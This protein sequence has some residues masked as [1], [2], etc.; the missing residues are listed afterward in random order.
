MVITDIRDLKPA[1]EIA[2][3]INVNTKLLATLALLSALQHS[4][5]PVLMI[6]CESK[7]GSFDHFSRMM[8]RYPFDLISAKLKPH[9]QTLDWLFANI[10][11]A[12]VLLVDS[13]LEIL[14]PE[15]IKFC[16]EF[17]DEEQTFGCGF[18]NGPQWLTDHAG[19][20][21]EKAYY[22]ERMWMPVTLLKTALVK[23]ALKAG[24]TFDAFILYNDFMPSRR[25]SSA[26]ARLRHR[27]P[28]LRKMDIKFP[29]LF[30]KTFYGHNPALVYYDTGADI[31][32]Y[33][34]YEREL[35]FAGLP[36]PFHR[37]YVAHAF[38]ATRNELG[39]IGPHGGDR[40]QAN[41]ALA[42]RRLKE[43]YGVSLS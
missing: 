20:F 18:F 2:V 36:E 3:I 21:L 13:D 30:R 9:G 26:V 43:I 39:R 14:S 16:R 22:Q 41:L 35:W 17:I 31:Y 40:H 33:L 15:I 28:W 10:S 24:R 5:M 34:R 38:G 32:Q 8:E 42:K 11:A 27:N 4:G 12:K 29:R 1:G 25:V 23:Q 19:T 37:R 6:E 7:D